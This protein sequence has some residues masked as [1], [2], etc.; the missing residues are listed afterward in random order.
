MFYFGGQLGEKTF[1]SIVTADGNSIQECCFDLKINCN[2]APDKN[3][4]R[5][6]R[7]TFFKIWLAEIFELLAQ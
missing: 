6:S 4:A 7:S 5:Y 3:A 1:F 2:F